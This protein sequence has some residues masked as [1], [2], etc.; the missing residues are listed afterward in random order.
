MAGRT[1]K[2]NQYHPTR[3]IQAYL[4]SAVIILIVLNYGRTITPVACRQPSATCATAMGRRQSVLLSLL[5]AFSP[6][7]E[8][9]SVSL[10]LAF[11]SEQKPNGIRLNKVFKKTHSRRQADALFESGRVEV[12][13]VKLTQKGGFYVVPYADKVTLDGTLIEGWEEMN[14][15]A[16]PNNEDDHDDTA[17][18]SRVGSNTGRKPTSG[19]ISRR[20]QSQQMS[21]KQFQYIKYWKPRGVTCTTDR[22]DRSNIIDAIM[23]DGYKPKHRIYPVGRLDKDTS[24]LI[25]LTSDGRLPNSALR[26]KNKQPKVYEAVVDRRIR[27]ADLQRLRDGEIFYRANT[28]VPWYCKYPYIRMY[29]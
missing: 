24:G 3:P 14:G 17:T 10:V 7:Y 22:S 21:T 1:V 9:E 18:T 12:N 23:Q 26:M 19:K 2:K 5:L 16:P 29:S 11:S 4:L 13:G 8:H 25:L 6:L 15:I 20:R 27:D 28:F